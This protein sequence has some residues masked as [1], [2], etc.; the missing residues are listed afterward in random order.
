MSSMTESTFSKIYEDILSSKLKPG[1]KLHITD[2]AKHYQAGM[3]PVREALSLLTATEMVI[4]TPQKGFK[5]AEM[6]LEDMEDLYKTRI[7]VEEAAL[8]LAIQ[9]G[10]ENWE[11]GVLSSFHL[12]DQFESKCT[13]TTMDDYLEWEKRHRNF[14]FDLL[15]GCGLLHLLKLQERLY[16]QT[17]RYRR[18][19]VKAGLRNKKHLK[20]A[21]KQKLI[22]QAA[23]EREEHEAVELLRNHYNQAQKVIASAL[24]Q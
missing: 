5:V 8:R 10:D 4:A 7:C 19:W 1:E 2:L 9:N 3:S 22:M 18:L 15:K 14:N 12:L 6:T 13:F 20:Y 17:E 11:A 16:F 23:L 24:K 21:Q